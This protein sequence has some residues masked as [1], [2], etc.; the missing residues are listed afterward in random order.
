MGGDGLSTETSG[1][2]L[3]FPKPEIPHLRIGHSGG[4][5]SSEGAI[6]QLPQNVGE[7]SLRLFYQRKQSVS[8][9]VLQPGSPRVGP[10]LLDD[11]QHSRSKE[12]PLL[13]RHP[14]KGIE[15]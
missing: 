13:W 6:I 3:V 10:N 1:V 2:A 14:F 4:D 7:G 15:S 5:Q 11:L 8:E 9:D 12:G